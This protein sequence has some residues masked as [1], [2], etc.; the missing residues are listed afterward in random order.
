MAEITLTDDERLVLMSVLDLRLS[1]TRKSTPMLLP[2]SLYSSELKGT[3]QIAGSLDLVRKNGILSTNETSRARYFNSLSNQAL[4]EG[5]PTTPS[6]TPILSTN[7]RSSLGKF[8]P[9]SAR[10]LL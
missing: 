3:R 8:E 6:V 1:L 7:C 5:T 4:V 10:S 9:S 2:L